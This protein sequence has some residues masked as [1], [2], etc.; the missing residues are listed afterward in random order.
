M[1]GFRADL[2]C[3]SRC[4]D[5]SLTPLELLEK[6]HQIGLQGLSITDHDTIKAY[7][8]ELF[9]KAE[10][11]GLILCSGVEF[12]CQLKG[13]N[14]HILGY[15]FDVTSK[16]LQEFCMKHQKRRRERNLKILLKL[17]QHQMVITEEE[18]E[19]IPLV[20]VIG[21]PHIAALMLQKGYVTSIKEAFDRYLGDGKCCFDQGGAFSV[22]ETI[23]LIHQAGGKA[24]IAH[25]HLIK[26][27]KIVKELLEKKFDGLEGYYALFHK[28][29]NQRWVDRAQEKGWLISGGSDFHGDL[30]P[31]IPLGA[32][33]VDEVTFQNIIQKK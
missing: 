1:T 22:D 2:H 32:S 29:D 8:G 6:A 5:G 33:W 12:S 14:V 31:F 18:L 25:P 21:R 15:G 20:H 23:T 24:F 7:D 3:H 9:K 27:S 17:R 30:R 11:L 28:A 4:S 16:Q 19:S 13:V 26:K 10:E